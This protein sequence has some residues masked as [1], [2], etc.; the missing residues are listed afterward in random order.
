MNVGCTQLD[1]LLQKIVYR[2][3]DGCTA[4]KIAQTLDVI[5]ALCRSCFGVIWDGEFIL[6]EPLRQG[7]G[8]VLKRRDG[9][10]DR[11]AESEFGGMNGDC[12]AGIGDDQSVTAAVLN[13]ARKDRHL[14][15]E[16]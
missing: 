3:Y 5:I 11:P 8:D 13:A 2:A 12:V 15:K 7:G 1:S 10:R 14:A 9:K 4:G 16:A 6:A